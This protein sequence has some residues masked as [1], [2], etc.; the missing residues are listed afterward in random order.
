[1]VRLDAHTLDLRGVADLEA[2]AEVF[3]GGEDRAFCSSHP[4]TRCDIPHTL[5]LKRK[6]ISLHAHKSLPHLTSG[7]LSDC[8]VFFF[9]LRTSRRSCTAQDYGHLACWLF[10]LRPS[11][12][13]CVLA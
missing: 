7:W 13:D 12:G 1:M 3:D 8:D 10:R 6:V 2:H 11:S 9:T 5:F 4:G